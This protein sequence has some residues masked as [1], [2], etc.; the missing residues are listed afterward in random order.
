MRRGKPN[1][2]FGNAG[3]IIRMQGW[4]KTYLRYCEGWY[5]G[6]DFWVHHAWIEDMRDGKIHEVTVPANRLDSF[7]RYHAVIKLS[8]E[9]YSEAGWPS[10][11]ESTM[12][13]CKHI[14]CKGHPNGE[15]PFITKFGGIDDNEVERFNPKRKGATA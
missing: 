13:P 7:R 14:G 8:A 1:Q 3:H 5:F 6:G 15:T 11:Y 9:D 10:G 2:C 12:L 4:K